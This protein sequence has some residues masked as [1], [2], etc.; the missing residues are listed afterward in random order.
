[1]ANACNLALLT[2]I[3][4]REVMLFR[5]FLLAAL[6]SLSSIPVSAQDVGK[7]VTAVPVQLVGHWFNT[8]NNATVGLIIEADKSCQ[9]YTERFTAARSS[10]PCKI[11]LHKD[12]TY[13][14]FLKG[15]DGQCGTFADFQFE[16]LPSLERLD[17]N[18]GDGVNFLL[19]PLRQSS[20]P[21]NSKPDISKPDTSK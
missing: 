12:S 3:F 15:A 9:M 14:I 11:E 8:Q 21:A 1:L 16:Y 2:I 18:T 13:F 19:E 7:A 4:G 10:R 20:V 6:A 5:V 17:L